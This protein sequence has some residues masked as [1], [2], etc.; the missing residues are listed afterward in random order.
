MK[1]KEHNL[2]AGVKVVY[3]NKE[4]TTGNR[5]HDLVELYNNHKFIKTVKMNEII[6]I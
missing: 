5:Y 3:K 2:D 4:Y 1:L 6:K